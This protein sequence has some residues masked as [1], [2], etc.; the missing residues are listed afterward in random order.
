MYDVLSILVV[1]TAA[2]TL[3]ECDDPVESP[4]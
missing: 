4:A 2:S 1:T 3:S